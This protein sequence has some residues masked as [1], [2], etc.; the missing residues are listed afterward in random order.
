[1][2]RRNKIV[3]KFNES[4]D[5]L[6]AVEEEIQQEITDNSEANVS[7]EESDFLEELQILPEDEK[8]NDN[9]E[10]LAQDHDLQI[11]EVVF[12]TIDSLQVI[13]EHGKEE[14]IECAQAPLVLEEV[15]SNDVKE[16]LTL[17]EVACESEPAMSEEITKL[18]RRPL[19][20]KTRITVS[21]AGLNSFEKDRRKKLIDETMTYEQ[22]VLWRRHRR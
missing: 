11:E 10:S 13:A 21:K 12:E 19:P 6:E 4:Q 2:A 17:E 5:Y 8:I 18:I 9:L 3:S 14:Q 7:T 20:S 15:V 22:W 1:M 16:S